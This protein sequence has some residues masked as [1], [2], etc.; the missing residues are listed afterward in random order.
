MNVKRIARYLKGVWSA[1]CLIEINRFTPFVNVYTDCD[2][3]GGQHQTCK[4]T[5]EKRDSY[6][7][8]NTTV[9]E[10]EF[11]RSRIVRSDNWNF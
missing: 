1:N 8:K 3:A 9:S 11:C 4:C 7:V 6:L 10:L 2:W 5:R